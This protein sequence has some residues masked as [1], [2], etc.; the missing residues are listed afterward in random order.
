RKFTAAQIASEMFLLDPTEM[1]YPVEG[2]SLTY[3]NQEHRNTRRVQVTY[4]PW[5]TRLERF[6]TGL[7]PTGEFVKFNVGGLLRGDTKTRFDAYRV[8]LGPDAPFMDVD[9]VRELEDWAPLRGVED[10][11]DDRDVARGLS[12]A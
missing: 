1:G 9:Q 4:L 8:A 3:A 6:L 10:T 12:V 2:S 7:L 11:S 5:I